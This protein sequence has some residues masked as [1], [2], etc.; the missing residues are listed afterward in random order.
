[1]KL[2]DNLFLLQWLYNYV[3]GILDREEYQK[4]NPNPNRQ[5]RVSK[6]REPSKLKPTQPTKMD[7]ED[8]DSMQWDLRSATSSSLCLQEIDTVVHSQEI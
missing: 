6:I 2:Q 7:V 3:Q 5:K 1:M 4:M 8:S